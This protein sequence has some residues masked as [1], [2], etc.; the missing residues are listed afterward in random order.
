MSIA[1]AKRALIRKTNT[2]RL[3]LERGVET[4][5]IGK[6]YYHDSAAQP[7]LAADGASRPRDQDFFESW[8][9]LDC[10]LDL[11]VRRS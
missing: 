7:A 2:P 5:V 3:S 9:Q 1:S 8:S 6:L 4:V 11:S 10:H